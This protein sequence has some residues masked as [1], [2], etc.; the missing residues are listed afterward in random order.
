MNTKEEI[1]KAVQDYHNGTFV[2]KMKAV[3]IEKT[4]GPEVLKN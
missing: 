4:G 3:K 2:A 1:L